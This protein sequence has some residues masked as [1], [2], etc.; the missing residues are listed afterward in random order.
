MISPQPITPTQDEKI[1]AALG[2]G[3][4]LLFF[5]GIL[6]PVIIW[7][8]QKEKSAYLAFQALQAAAFQLLMVLAYFVLMICYVCSSGATFLALPLSAADETLGMAAVLGTTVFQVALFAVICFGWF[9]FII[10][11]LVA[12]VMILQGH[13]F[14]YAILGQRL[15]AYLQRQAGASL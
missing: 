12:S 9:G 13:D 1:M 7:I 8:T 11:G 2:H 6:V 14:R 3:A 15:E 5:A 10:Y 4:I